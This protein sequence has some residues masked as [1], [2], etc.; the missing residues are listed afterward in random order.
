MIGISVLL[1]LT[2]LFGGLSFVSW[3]RDR[4]E[5][6]PGFFFAFWPSAGRSFW[7]WASLWTAAG[8]AA[9]WALVASGLDRAAQTWFEQQNPLGLLLP[10]KAISYGDNLAG[11]FW[12]LTM[13]DRPKG[14]PL[15][16]R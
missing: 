16:W 6:P 4:P 11:Y 14:E 1:G 12:K 7:G 2:L 13:K 15:R 9:T 3:R 5:R 8:I 10:R